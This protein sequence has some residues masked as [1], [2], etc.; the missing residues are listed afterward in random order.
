[1]RKVYGVLAAAAMSVSMAFAPTA[2]AATEFGT[3]CAGASPL[4]PN[5]TVV[6]VAQAPGA[7]LPLTAPFSG[8]VTK[9]KSNVSIPLPP[10][11]AF[12]QRLRVFRSS[13]PKQ[14]QTVGESPLEVMVSGINTHEARVPVQ[15]GDRLGS[16]G[17]GTFGGMLCPTTSEADVVGIKE[18]D[19][20]P[21]GRAEYP[22]APKIQLSLSA[23]IEPDGDGDGFG[24]ETQDKCPQSAALQEPCPATSIDAFS[25]P[26]GK[27]LV[28]IL[29]TTNYET[30]VAVTASA[31]VPKGKKGKGTTTTALEPVTQV[32]TPGKL[33]SYTINF[34]GALKTALK[35]LSPKKSITLEIGASGKGILGTPVT[36]A[37]TVK[38]KGQAKAKPKR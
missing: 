9:W 7:A 2:G 36:D 27:G 13:G 14:F 35:G 15:A 30:S 25:L 28:R 6:Q 16:I 17:A 31:K 37:L 11:F 34:N 3:N 10:G 4:P 18:G 29:V 8:V 1:M 21:G 32:V 38:V 5:L 19:V 23:V 26:P 12:T 22:E 24:D 33:V 20:P